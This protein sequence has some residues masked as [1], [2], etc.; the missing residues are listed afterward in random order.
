MASRYPPFT[1]NDKPG[2]AT[3]SR[4]AAPCEDPLGY[5][6]QD[7][8]GRIAYGRVIDV[9]QPRYG[10]Q[11]MDVL[12]PFWFYFNQLPQ[13]VANLGAMKGS[14]AASVCSPGGGLGCS[15]GSYVRNCNDFTVNERS[16]SV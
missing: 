4:R 15:W 9:Q 7:R 10:Q 6:A 13:L 2:Y 14:N 16:S 1:D 11:V 8:A 12:L 3:A 5:P